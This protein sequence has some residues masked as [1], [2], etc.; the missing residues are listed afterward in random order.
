MRIAIIGS[1]PSGCLLLAAFA[2]AKKQGIETPEI[3]VFERQEKLGGMWNLNWRTGIDADGDPVLQSMYNALWTNAAKEQHEF[4]DYSYE[5][6]WGGPTGSYPPRQAQIDYLHGYAK[7]HCA[8]FTTVRFNTTVKRV[9]YSSGSFT[10]DVCENACKDYSE[11]FDYVIV[12]TGHFSIPNMPQFPGAET[13]SGRILHSHDLKDAR[14]YEGQRVCVVGSSLSAEDITSM[15]YK[16]G[17]KQI[18]LTHRKK[19]K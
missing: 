19:N 15:I 10:L 16:Y 17:A 6:H 5:E 1:G 4:P 7:K 14:L 13:F 8:D 12:A 2:H 18:I 9:A 11:N 3:V